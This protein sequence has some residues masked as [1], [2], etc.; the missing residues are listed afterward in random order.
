MIIFNSVLSIFCSSFSFLNINNSNPT[1][2]ILFLHMSVC[3]MQVYTCMLGLACM[4]R[5]EV[6]VETSS[7]NYL[8]TLF[9]S[10]AGSITEPKLTISTRVDGHWALG[11]SCLQLSAL[12][13]RENWHRY[14]FLWVSG[15]WTRI[16]RA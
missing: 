12:G 16:F 8:C 10:E 4:W 13:Y 7:F 1:W 5:T 2:S 11:L 3:C 15:I 9:F 14:C 6:G